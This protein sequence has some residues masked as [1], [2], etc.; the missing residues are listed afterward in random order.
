M[1]KKRLINR[2][3]CEGDDGAREALRRYEDR[4]STALLVLAVVFIGLYAV[5][6]LEP[7]AK[8]R[9]R[10]AARQWIDAYSSTRLI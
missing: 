2:L 8:E 1:V 10:F 7:Q 6:V 3:G 5:P 9:V 4:T